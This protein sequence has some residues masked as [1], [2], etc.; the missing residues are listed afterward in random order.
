MFPGSSVSH[1][2]DPPNNSMS[3][4]STWEPNWHLLVCPAQVLFLVPWFLVTANLSWYP[5]HTSAPDHGCSSP[6]LLPHYVEMDMKKIKENLCQEREKY[7]FMMLTRSLLPSHVQQTTAGR[8]VL[9]IF[10][11]LPKNLFRIQQ[12]RVTF[13]S[14]DVLTRWDKIRIQVC[15]TSKFVCFSF[16]LLLVDLNDLVI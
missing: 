7:C 15:L 5:T 6:R 2:Y 12:C 3:F 14:L 8:L 4:H 16:I 9:C 10:S 1:P 11:L 13:S